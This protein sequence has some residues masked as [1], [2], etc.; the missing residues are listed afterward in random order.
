MVKVTKGDILIHSIQF[1][2]SIIHKEKMNGEPK[3]TE[4]KKGKVFQ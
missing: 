3:E 4:E 2:M 1:S